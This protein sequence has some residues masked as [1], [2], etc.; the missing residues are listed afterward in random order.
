V[1]AGI[2]DEIAKCLEEWS[3]RFPDAPPPRI[4][5][6]EVERS[7][8]NKLTEDTKGPLN[9]INIRTEGATTWS[10]SQNGRMLSRNL[11]RIRRSAFITQM[12]MT[13]RRES[14][15]K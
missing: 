11:R 13:K 15:P 9:Q 10:T 1:C 4:L 3:A 8:Y 14:L 7:P 12:M 5:I 2:R 6:D